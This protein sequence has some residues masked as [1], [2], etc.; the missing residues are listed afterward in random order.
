[1]QKKNKYED[2]REHQSW[3]TARP[4]DTIAMAR[5]V[6]FQ[7]A[8]LSVSEKLSRKTFDSAMK[9]GIARSLRESAPTVTSA[10]RI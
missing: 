7:T 5:L 9:K 6:I 4:L 2:E 1:M 3:V 10:P 8:L